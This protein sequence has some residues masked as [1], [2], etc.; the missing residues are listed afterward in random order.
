[1]YHSECGVDYLCHRFELRPVPHQCHCKIYSSEE[2]IY[3]CTIF[4]H[5]HTVSSPSSMYNSL[6]IP[7]L[8]ILYNRSPLNYVIP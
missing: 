3:S 6:Y 5:L 8:G 2:H 7:F 1:M 4:H